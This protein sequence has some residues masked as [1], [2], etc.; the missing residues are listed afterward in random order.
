MDGPDPSKMDIKVFIPTPIHCLH[1][2]KVS[3]IDGKRLHSSSCRENKIK[4]KMHD[5]MYQNNNILSENSVKIINDHHPRPHFI[6]I[7]SSSSLFT[8]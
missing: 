7:Y 6:V 2:E 8:L 4:Y 1:F 5:F 3:S